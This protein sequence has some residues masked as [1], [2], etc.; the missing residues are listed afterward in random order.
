MSPPSATTRIRCR[1]ST[2]AGSLRRNASRRGSRGICPTAQ[3]GRHPAVRAPARSAPAVDRAQYRDRAAAA[4][5]GNRR[6]WQSVAVHRSQSRRRDDRI[7]AAAASCRGCRPEAVGPRLRIWPRSAWSGGRSCA[8]S[9]LKIAVEQRGRPMAQ[10]PKNTGPQPPMPE[11][12]Q[13]PPGHT[14]EMRPV[15]DHGETSYK[16]CGKL[17]GRAALITGADS[18]IGRAVAIAFAREGAEVLISYLDEHED[19]KETARWVEEAGRRAVLVAGDVADQAH[20][21]AL[22]DRAL[23]EFGHLDILVNNA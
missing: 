13:S 12:R 6:A 16:G 2:V 17:Q 23:R 19:A 8:P 22:V 14:G 10:D 20:C 3:S 21:R 1:R 4:D 5:L 18:G 9:V 15:P 11:Q 7:E